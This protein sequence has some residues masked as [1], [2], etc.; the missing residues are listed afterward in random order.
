MAKKAKQPKAGKADGKQ[1]KKAQGGRDPLGA[2]TTLVAVL[3]GASLVA[4]R[5]AG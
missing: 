5:V 3:F 2:A 1:V 4:E